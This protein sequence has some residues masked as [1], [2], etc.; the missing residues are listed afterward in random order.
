MLLRSFC[1]ILSNHSNTPATME[2]A[3]FSLK[4]FVDDGGRAP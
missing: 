1:G 3:R 4:W 2:V